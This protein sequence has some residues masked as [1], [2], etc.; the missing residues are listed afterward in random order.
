MHFTFYV[1]ILAVG[2]AR[3]SSWSAIDPT[4]DFAAASKTLPEMLDQIHPH[5]ERIEALLRERQPDV[6]L[7]VVLIPPRYRLPVPKRRA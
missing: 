3:D 4:T 2:K 1:E 6:E 7:Q 5:Y